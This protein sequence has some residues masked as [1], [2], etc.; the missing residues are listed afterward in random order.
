MEIFTKIVLYN[1]ICSLIAI[2]LIFID[3]LI[4]ENLISNKIESINDFLKPY[5]FIIYKHKKNG[6]YGIKKS[7]DKNQ[8]ECFQCN[9]LF[10]YNLLKCKKTPK[11]IGKLYLKLVDRQIKRK[12][13][14]TKRKTF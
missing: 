2:I 5:G 13:K 9:A 6:V 7:N 8:D 14:E 12:I 10:Y 11:L 4:G 3:L 1:L